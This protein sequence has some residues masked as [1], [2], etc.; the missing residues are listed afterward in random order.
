MWEYWDAHIQD[1][2]TFFKRVLKLGQED[3]E[4]GERE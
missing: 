3:P 2:I 1:T 4:A